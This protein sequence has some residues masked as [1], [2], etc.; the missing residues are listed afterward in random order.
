MTLIYPMFTLVVFTLL[1]VCILGGAR[2][3]AVQKKQVRGGYFKTFDGPRPPEAL[4]RLS[5]NY[6]N[7]LEMTPL[8]YVACLCAMYLNLATETMIICAWG[9]VIA[10]MVHSAYHIFFN[11]PLYRLI[12]FSISCVFLLIQWITIVQ[13]V[14]SQN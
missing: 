5:R 2:Y 8:F 7:L 1:I 11:I 6:S 9:Y 4:V 10:R 3:I 12:I 14:A 13:F